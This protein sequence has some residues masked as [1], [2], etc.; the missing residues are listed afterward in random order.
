MNKF[1]KTFYLWLALFTFCNVVSLFA[2]QVGKPFSLERWM[3]YPAA[4]VFQLPLVLV[5]SLIHQAVNRCFS[6]LPV[7]FKKPVRFVLCLLCS[8]VFMGTYAASQILYQQIETFISLDS[9]RAVLSNPAQVIPDIQNGLGGELIWIG[10]LAVLFSVIYTRWYHS[11][12]RLHSPTVFAVLSVVFLASGAGG[13]VLVYKSDSKAADRIRKD[14]LPTTYLTFSIIDHMLPSAAPTVDFLTDLVFEPRVSMDAFFGDRELAEKPDVYLIML[15]SISWDRYGCTGY[16]R[17]V[18]PHIDALASECM[19]FPKSY[20]IANHSSYAQTGTHASM[21]PLRRTQL[22]QFEK[23]NYP[24]T[25]LFDVLSHAGYRT[26]FFSAQNEDWLGMKT[27]IE[28]NTTLQHFFHS[29]SVLG[30]NIGIESKIDDETVRRHAEEY[31]SECA[32]DEPVFM[33]LNFQATHFPYAVPEGAEQRYQPCSTD[34]FSFNYTEYDREHLDTV[35]NK[36]DNA[37][38]YIDRQVGAFIEYLKSAGRFENSLIVVASD[39]GEA[40]YKHGLPTHGTSLFEDQIRTTTLFKLPGG[41]Q[42]G[43]R[44]DPISLID[45]NPTI[46]EVLGLPNHPNFQGRQVMAQPRRKPIYLI[47]HSLVKSHGIIDWPWK[48]F[49]S[50]RD[51]EQLLNLEIDADESADLSDEYPEVMERMKHA[52]QV[53]QRRQL[54]YYNVLPQAE[55]DGYYPPQH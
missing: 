28:A 1:L 3:L 5:L 38:L 46:L 40:F 33:Y 22:D 2:V 50:E 42:R 13:M 26:A 20:A 27:F 18:S 34:G 54:Y 36:F 6:A 43:V 48:F 45:L 39:H 24:K 30:S 47:S 29:K 49:T 21:Y 52:L 17:N 16:E 10:I 23:V 25:M 15:E 11:Q 55:R 12:H 19:V 31:L 44:E 37:M 35:I 41:N 53:Y 32:A 51:G 14:L 7:R 4:W 8:F 9:Y